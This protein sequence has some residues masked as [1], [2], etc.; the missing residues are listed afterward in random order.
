MAQSEKSDYQ[1]S[2]YKSSWGWM[3]LSQ[4]VF[5]AVDPTAF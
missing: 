5:M 1:N 3:W 2:D 4:P